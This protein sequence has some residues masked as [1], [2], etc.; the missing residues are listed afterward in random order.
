MLKAGWPRELARTVLPLATYSHMFA[1]VNLLN[2]FKFLT[3]RCD[4]H[5]QYE[6]RQYANALAILISHIVPASYAAWQDSK[7]AE[8]VFK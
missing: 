2:L 3:L 1:S 7:V 4:E 5:A 8:K 6:I